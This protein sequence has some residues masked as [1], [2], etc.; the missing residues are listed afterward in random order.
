MTELFGKNRFVITKR[1]NNAF[2]QG[3]QTEKAM[4][5]IRTLLDQTG[6]LQFTASMSFCQSVTA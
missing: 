5:N 3:S 2:N 1:I 6:Q 4:C